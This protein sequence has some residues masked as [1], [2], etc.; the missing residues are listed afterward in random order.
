M[1]TIHS[2]AEVTDVDQHASLLRRRITL[3]LSSIMRIQV[4]CAPKFHN[5]FWQKILFYF[6]R[7]ILQE[8]IIASLFIIKAIIN[9]F[10]ATFHV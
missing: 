3:F 4:E 9:P 10:S 8:Q 1:Q 2:G 5:D 6:S 7:V